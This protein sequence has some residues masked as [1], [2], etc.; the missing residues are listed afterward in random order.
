M[1]ST[2]SV[3]LP[4]GKPLAVDYVSNLVEEAKVSGLVR[5]AFDSLGLTTSVVAPP[6]FAVR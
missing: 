5:R 2:T 3:A 1:N 6:Q 4:K